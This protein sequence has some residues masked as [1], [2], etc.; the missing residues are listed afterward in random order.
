MGLKK[1]KAAGLITIIWSLAFPHTIWTSKLGVLCPTIS[2]TFQNKQSDNHAHF[3]QRLVSRGDKVGMILSLFSFFISIT[4]HV[5][6]RVQQNE[7][8][9]G[10]TVR[11]C[12]TISP[13]ARFIASRHL[14]CSHRVLGERPGRQSGMQ[15]VFLLHLQVQSFGTCIHK[16][17]CLLM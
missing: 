3:T 14:T 12:A 7:C 8:L 6:K 13:F 2:V 10:E 11:K 17:F 15:S 5:Y 9:E 4:F 16:H 1:T